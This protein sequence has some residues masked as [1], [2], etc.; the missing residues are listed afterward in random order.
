M[1]CCIQGTLQQNHRKI[2]PESQRLTF[3]LKHITSKQTL[4]RK[5]LTGTFML[6]MLNPLWQKLFLMK[7][8]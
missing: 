5:G 6:K 4:E 2:V 1:T 7:A 8:T 3:T